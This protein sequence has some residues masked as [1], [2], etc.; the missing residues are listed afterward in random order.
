MVLWES[1][2]KISDKKY[3]KGYIKYLI[4]PPPD[5]PGN[6]KN[7]AKKNLNH[8]F[9]WFSV[10][11]LPRSQQFMVYTLCSPPNYTCTMVCALCSTVYCNKEQYS[12]IHLTALLS[13]I[14][15]PCTIVQKLHHLKIQNYKICLF[16]WI[17]APLIL[18]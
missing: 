6:L 14:R 18:Q 5:L 2:N 4:I 7:M 16:Y 17:H 8:V 1:K 11:W 10:S 3:H 9:C 15:L 12:T 13:N